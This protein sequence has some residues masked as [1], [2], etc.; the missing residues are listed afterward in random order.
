MGQTGLL[1]KENLVYVFIY[2]FIFNARPMRVK[3]VTWEIPSYDFNKVF[4][5]TEIY[6]PLV[7]TDI[8]S[9]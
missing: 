6:N 5:L 3:L 1:L 2:L 4:K 8:Q 9:R 7:N